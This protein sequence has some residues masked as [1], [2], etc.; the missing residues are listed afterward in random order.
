[1]DISEVLYSLAVKFIM[2]ALVMVFALTIFGNTTLIS[3]LLSALTLTLFAYIVGDLGIL[4][5]FGNTITAVV[6][7]VI[8]LVILI[9]L[10][11][12]IPD[13]NIGFFYAMI[14]GIIIGGGEY[15]FHQFLKERVIAFARERRG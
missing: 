6:D 2:I 4:P 5:N 13:I 12:L 3:A 10:N 14:I 11:A 9:A 1:M 8:A 15:I 7:G